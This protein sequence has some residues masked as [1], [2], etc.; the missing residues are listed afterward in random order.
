MAICGDSIVH[1]FPSLNM[2]IDWDKQTG[3]WNVYE[4]SG[5]LLGKSPEVVI[6]GTTTLVHDSRE[7]HGW[8]IVRGKFEKTEKRII[9]RKG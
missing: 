7:R 4:E 5:V 9:I 6:L 1:D 8:A 3:Q 2:K